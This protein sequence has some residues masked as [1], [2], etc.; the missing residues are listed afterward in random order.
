M[1]NPANAALVARLP[2]LGLNQCH[3][4]AGCL[5][6]AVW[7]RASGHAPGWGIKDY[8]IFYFDDGDL[9]WDAEDGVIRAVD[10]LTAD[11]GV[12]VEVRNQARV[13]LWYA[14]RFGTGYPQLRSARDGIDRYL[15]A[16][17]CVGIEVA[18]GEF[19]APDGLD[20]LARGVLR[21]NPRNPRPALFREKAES[22]RSRWPWLTVVEPE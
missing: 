8:D 3:L 17:T 12:T 1:A 22:Y 11:L 2:A 6:Q 9:S 19:Y 13:H 7:N 15:I 4:V 20:D 14:E 18:T 10:A 16:C 5:F 21:M